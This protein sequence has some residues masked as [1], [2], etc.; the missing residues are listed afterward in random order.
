MKAIVAMIYGEF[1]SVVVDGE[2]M[3]QVD[4]NIAGPVGNR[5]MVRFVRL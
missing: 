1:E 5:L 3:E 4:G 2:G